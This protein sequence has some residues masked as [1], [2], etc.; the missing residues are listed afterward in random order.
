M[1]KKFK[2]LIEF[3]KQFGYNKITQSYTFYDHGYDWGLD[4]MECLNENGDWKTMKTPSIVRG[5]LE[6]VLDHY[7]GEIE[8]TVSEVN[9][10]DWNRYDVEVEIY[11]K[12]N[13]LVYLSSNVYYY[14]SESDGVENEFD[15]EDEDDIVGKEC[16]E[17]LT[18]I[19]NPEEVTI[20]YEGS[21]D[22][23]YIESYG[24][25]STG[26]RVDL[27][28]K[29][30]D[31]CYRVLERFSGWEINEGSRGEIIIN[32]NSMSINHNWNVEDEEFIELDIVVTEE[33]ID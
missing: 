18:S 31:L 21:G 3:L 25:T 11:P 14:G 19:G 7:A 28:S 30:E 24:E 2:Y 27:P 16:K 9:Y 32:Q 8:D 1:K 33:S 5:L 4:E 15:D 23:G 26:E 6:D 29:I 17:F 10:G 12:E 22:S 13:K 20:T